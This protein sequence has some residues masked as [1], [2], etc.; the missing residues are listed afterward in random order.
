MTETPGELRDGRHKIVR[1]TI[2]AMDGVMFRYQGVY[3]RTW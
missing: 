1:E 2:A 3:P